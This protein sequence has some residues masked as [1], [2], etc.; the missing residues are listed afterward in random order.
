MAGQWQADPMGRAQYRYFDGA[1]WTHAVATNGVQSEESRDLALPGAAQPAAVATAAPVGQPM[2]PAAYGYQ[3]AYAPRPAGGGMLMTAGIMTIVSAV[4]W[5]F[6]GIAFFQ[7]A[8]VADSSLF[9]DAGDKASG[10]MTMLGVFQLLFAGGSLA[11]GIGSVRKAQWGQISVVVLSAIAMLFWL[12]VL[13][14]VGQPIFLIS[15]LWFAVIGGLAFAENKAV[16]QQYQA[17]RQNRLS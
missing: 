3:P 15:V 2:Q 11:A 10:V 4:G 9:G 16:F 5:I 8:D 12:V 1:N 14:Y 7:A 17:A 13:I 6:L